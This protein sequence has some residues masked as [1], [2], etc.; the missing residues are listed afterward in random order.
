M[1]DLGYF[2][3]SNIADIWHKKTAHIGRLKS[4]AA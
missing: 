2:G 4:R 1:P 3:K